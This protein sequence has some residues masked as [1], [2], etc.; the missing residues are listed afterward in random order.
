VGVDIPVPPPAH[1]D[2]TL[3]GSGRVPVHELVEAVLDLA[4]AP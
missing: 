4:G 2:L 1:P 3:D